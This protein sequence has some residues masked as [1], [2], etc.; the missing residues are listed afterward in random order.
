MPHLACC[1]LDPLRV[2]GQA[3]DI[4]IVAEEELLGVYLAVIHYPKSS[5]MIHQVAML[6]ACKII[7]SCAAPLIA[8][9]KLQTKLFCR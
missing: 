1:H 6:V 8:M 4:I 5:N 3:E 2:H 7:G 9:D